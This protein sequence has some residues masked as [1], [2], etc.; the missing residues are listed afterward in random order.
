[1]TLARGSVG[2]EDAVQIESA[3]PPIVGIV[4]GLWR[5]DGTS[6]ERIAKEGLFPTRLII[7]IEGIDPSWF[8]A[9]LTLVPAPVGALPS[10]QPQVQGVFPSAQPAPE[11][12]ELAQQLLRSL[13]VNVHTS[14]QTT[15]TTSSG[16]VYT[17]K[18][19]ANSFTFNVTRDGRPVATYDQKT[20]DG[21]GPILMSVGTNPAAVVQALQQWCGMDP[22]Q[23]QEFLLTVPA[24][25]PDLHPLNEAFIDGLAAEFRQAGAEVLAP[26]PDA[27]IRELARKAASMIN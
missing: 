8:R 12:P 2:I 16:T 4:T 24:P 27:S 21:I 23:I 20:A 7:R 18:S 11:L 17:T 1:M 6:A 10:Q 13:P 5:R 3:N 19:S 26:G 14:E 15:T 22:G 9:S 25:I